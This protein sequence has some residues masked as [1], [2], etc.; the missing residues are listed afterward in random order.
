MAIEKAKKLPYDEVKE[1]KKNITS[2]HAENKAVEE[3]STVNRRP[4]GML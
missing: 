1:D 2:I 3:K 4:S